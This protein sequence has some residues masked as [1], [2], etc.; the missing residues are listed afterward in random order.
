MMDSSI[1]NKLAWFL[2]QLDHVDQHTLQALQF[3]QQFHQAMM[4]C[5]ASAQ[6]QSAVNQQPS[7]SQCSSNAPNS[8]TTTPAFGLKGVKLRRHVDGTTVAIGYICDSRGHRIEKTFTTLEEA[9]LHHDWL[10]FCHSLNN[11]N[12]RPVF[13][14]PSLFA[15][16]TAALRAKIKDSSQQ[17]AT[18]CSTSNI[19]TSMM[20]GPGCST[21]RNYALQPLQPS[22]ILN[23][24]Q[25]QQQHHPVTPGGFTTVQGYTNFCAATWDRQ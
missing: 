12:A 14:F 4:D 20:A 1:D 9:A 7:Y 22:N 24:R 8:N 11:Q 19:C 13:N 3:L 18:V 21:Q 17:G 10:V 5:V 16:P 6:L 2:L 23:Q 25:Q 15:A